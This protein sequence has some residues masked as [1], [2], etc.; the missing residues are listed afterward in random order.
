MSAAAPVRILVDTNVWLDHYLDRGARHDDA[1]RLVEAAADERAVLYVTDGILKDF[2]FVFQ[3]TLRA[4]YRAEGLE[5]TSSLAAAIE[6]TAWGCLRSLMHVA[7][8][9]PMG[10]ADVWQAFTYRRTHG[11]FEDDLLVAAARR[12]GADFIASSD[13]ELARRSPI[14]CLP[15]AKVPLPE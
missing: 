2:F 14:T 15:A 10:T 3:R 9:V 12:A 5:V 11:D 1:Q 8:V 6:E 7:I 13:A 4:A